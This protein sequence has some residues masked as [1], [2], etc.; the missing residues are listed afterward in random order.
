M[1][2]IKDKD[3]LELAR[4]AQIER[5]AEKKAKSAAKADA[6]RRVTEQ[7]MAVKRGENELADRL[8]ELWFGTG[9]FGSSRYD[10]EIKERISKILS[11]G[12]ENA[13]GNV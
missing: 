6:K 9:K 1:A 2:G 4:K 11:L 7:L 10:Q 3:A 8:I 13:K 12:Q 5:A